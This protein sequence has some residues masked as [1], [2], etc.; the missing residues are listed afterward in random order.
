[1]KYPFSFQSANERFMAAKQGGGNVNPRDQM[2]KD[3]AAAFDAFVELSANLKEGTKVWKIG[4][5]SCINFNS[6]FRYNL[7]S[8][9]NV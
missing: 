7:Y 2:L 4:R 5:L 3:L 1:M 6:V 8:L 9:S